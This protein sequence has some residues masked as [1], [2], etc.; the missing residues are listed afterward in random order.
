MVSSISLFIRVDKMGSIFSARKL[1]LQTTVP[2]FFEDFTE[3][4]EEAGRERRLM[5]KA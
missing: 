1:S 3:A 2:G 5:E 4:K